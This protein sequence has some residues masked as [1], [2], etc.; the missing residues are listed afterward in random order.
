MIAGDKSK[1]KKIFLYFILLLILILINFIVSSKLVNF[2]FPFTSNISIFLLINLNIVL[3]LALLIVIF[4]NLAKIFFSKSKGVFGASLQSKLV[5]FSII[6]SVIPVSIVF[7]FSINII[8]NSINKWFDA[9]VEQALKSSV[10]LMQKY[11][12]QLEQDLVEQTSILSKLVTTKGFLYQRNYGELKNFVVDYL[13]NNRI[14]GV[15]VYNKEGNR[16]LSEDKKFYINFLVDK[17]TVEEIVKNA[18][19]VAK[20]EFFGENQIYWVGAPVSAKTSEKVILGALFV[21]K[22]VPPAQAE[23]VSKI[24]DSYRNYSQI[25][26]FAEPVKN[27]YKILLVLMTLLVALAGIWGSIVFS[28]NITEPLGALAEASKKISKGDLDVKL[29]EVGDY[30]LRVLIKS[31]NE[32][33]RR[34]KEHTEQLNKKNKEL[35][36]MY[37]QIFRD[38]QYI[39]TIFK[40]TKSA[41]FLFDENLKILK[42]NDKAKEILEIGEEWWNEILK[43]LKE[44]FKNHNEKSKSF[45]KDLKVHNTQKTFSITL[46]KVYL[47]HDE[48]DNIILFM[49]DITDILNAKKYEIWKE[50]ASRIAHEIKNPLTPIK[51]NAERVLRKLKEENGNVSESIQKSIKTIIFEVNDLYK[52]VNEFNEF[53]RMPNVYKTYFD[54]ND[55]L[56]EVVEFY[57][58]SHNNINFIY[59]KTESVDF[60]GDVSQIKRLFHNLL[61]N[62]IAAVNDNGTIEIDISEN[63]EYICLSFKDNGVGIKKEDVDKIFLPYFSKKSGGTGLGL[64][65]VKKIV[66]EHDGEIKVESVENEYTVFNIRFNKTN[67][68]K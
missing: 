59:K 14:D 19:Q 5:I 20:Y 18:K 46:S 36:N 8:N 12:N 41:I 39:D 48:P 16:I 50:I 27:S 44:F 37:R 30:E 23:K 13:Q 7:I 40:N 11:Q 60:Y 63:K 57:K 53:A 6:L 22:I 47:S 43:L 38:N 68:G 32:M 24:M 4:R 58:S 26:F 10:D 34:L 64:A 25:K 17:E 66:E 52:M 28:K 21:Y 49:D 2:E 67:W 56:N 55:V 1:Q 15:A 9:Q 33:A 35:D 42:F 65:I 29:E 61:N 31:F 54:L 51:L 62:A 3:L 45:Q